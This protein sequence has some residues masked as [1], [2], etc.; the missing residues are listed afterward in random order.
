MTAANTSSFPRLM[1]DVGGTNARFALQEASGA[2]PSQV[3]TFAVA[4]HDN[5]DG[6][7]KAY[8]DQVVGP[9]PRQGAVGIANPI[10]GDF[11]RMTNSPWAFSIEAVRVALGLD[12]LLFI[13]D[14]TALALSLPSLQPEHLRRIGSAGAA[15][16]RGAIGL[17][18]P[19]T[20]LGVSGLLHDTA[21][22]LVPL[23]GEG[24]HVSL[25]SANAREDAVVAVLRDRFGHASAERALQGAGLVAMYE[26][27]CKIDGVGAASLDP[28]GVTA[29]ALAGSDARCVEV[30]ELFFAFLG[31]VAGNLALTLGARGGVYIGGGIVPRL[32]DWID[33]SA[34]RER[35]IAKGRFRGY[36]DA[37]PT[38]LIHAE[39]SP[40]LI[41][42]ARALDEL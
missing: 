25:A 11:L 30:I 15:D 20:G 42:A 10:V 17:L 31:S 37:I 8:L 7:M 6:A 1:G 34:F 38:W 23:G 24:G 41:G 29:A 22:H 27:L 16:P 40:A 28:A 36:L 4:D 14:F 32:G 26:A 35:F 33:R 18:G 19:G 5:I 21:G 39:T 12:R 2:Q 13:N 3:R 9:R